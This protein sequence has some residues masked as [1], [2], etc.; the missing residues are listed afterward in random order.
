MWNS[1][2]YQPGNPTISERSLIPAKKSQVQPEFQSYRSDAPF[3]ESTI[4]EKNIRS[5]IPPVYQSLIPKSTIKY[6][7]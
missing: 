1:K 4:K 6:G 2:F 7:L 5:D 3:A